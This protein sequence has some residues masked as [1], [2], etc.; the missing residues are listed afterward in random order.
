MISDVG[1]TIASIKLID[2]TIVNFFNKQI[3]S[4]ENNFY[5][6]FGNL[7]YKIVPDQS[8]LTQRYRCAHY[9][10][11]YSQSYI[12]RANETNM[13][14]NLS[15]TNLTSTSQGGFTAKPLY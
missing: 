12:K 8:D 1:K 5:D 11:S 14:I 15:D 10:Y 4:G 2:G 6:E 9:S 3:E 13:V 7:R